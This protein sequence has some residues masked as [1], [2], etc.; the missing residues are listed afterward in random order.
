MKLEND[1]RDQ[2]IALSQ[3]QRMAEKALKMKFEADLAALSTPVAPSGAQVTTPK[4]EAE[5]TA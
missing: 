1:Y 3:T 4:T 5:L 2:E